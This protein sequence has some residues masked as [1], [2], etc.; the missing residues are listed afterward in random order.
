MASAP[1]PKVS[2]IIPTHNMALFAGQAIESVL[3]QSLADFE[4]IVV[5]DGSTDQT[6][7]VVGRYS[8]PRLRYVYQENRG[9]PGARNTGIRASSGEILA[10]LDAD[11]R[12]HPNKLA[13]Q[14]CFLDAQRDI[15][16]C[17]N[18]SFIVDADQQILSLRRAPATAELA[19]IVSGYPFA[20]S[21]VVMRREWA[22]RVGLYD[23]S[24]VLNSEDLNFHIRLLLAG[25]RLGGVPEALAYR[26][27]HR[28]R[29]F[30]NIAGK[31]K[32][33]IR[34]LNTAFD[35]PRCPAEVLDLRPKAYASHFVSWGFQAAVQGEADLARDL[36]RRGFSLDPTWLAQE[37]MALQHFLAHAS[38]R[39]GSDPEASLRAT[40]AVLPEDLSGCQRQFEAVLGR[41]YLLLALQHLLWGREVQGEV[42]MRKAKRHGAVLD[43]AFWRML[44]DQIYSYYLEFG[45][46]AVE[47]VLRRLLPSLAGLS[48]ATPARHFAATCAFNQAR[49]LY[50]TGQFH[51][52]TARVL[53]AIFQSPAYVVNRGALGL[54]FRSLWSIP[55][56]REDSSTRA[57]RPPADPDREWAL[58][59]AKSAPA[60]GQDTFNGGNS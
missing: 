9:L 43:Q 12:F 57:T 46:Q 45:E 47:V 1:T 28:G 40:C 42:P 53:Q 55:R 49:H 51:R 50:R 54:L 2:V 37:G 11:D 39:D 38:V 19:G 7:E 34:A 32:T 31:V 30:R 3:G 41:A 25:C 21:D 5:D 13:T 56:R 15:G 22:E 58:R 48:S 60:T 44:N 14:V 23:E 26:L 10:F 4:L 59:G 18:S 24:Y 36:L 6:A 35:D 33:Y 16:L 52:A 8:D 29:R 27:V 17:Y 20:P